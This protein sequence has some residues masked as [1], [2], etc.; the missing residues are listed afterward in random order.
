MLTLKT[1]PHRKIGFLNLFHLLCALC[2]P[3]T[4]LTRPNQ[5]HLIHQFYY[6]CVSIILSWINR[7][8]RIANQTSATQ[9]TK[10]SMA[11]VSHVADEA[12]VTNLNVSKV[13][14]VLKKSNSRISGQKFRTQFR[15]KASIENAFRH[16]A[17]PEITCNKNTRRVVFTDFFN[18]ISA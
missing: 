17:C 2:R 3:L 6:I 4:C 5:R 9:S 15:K 10:R 14:I 13:R 1:M 8:I 18:T 7:L 16:C 11:A 12:H